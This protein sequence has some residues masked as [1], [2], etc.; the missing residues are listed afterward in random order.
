MK[1]ALLALLAAAVFAL[2]GGL[3]SAQAPG[4]SATTNVSELLIGQRAT[5]EV[6]VRVPSGAT[7]E[8]DTGADSWNGVAVVA[9]NRGEVVREG[10]E[11]V[12]R[13]ALIVAPF[14]PGPGS[15]EPSI[16]VI[17]ADGA[18]LRTLPAI[19]W[20]V[21]PSLSPGAPL[22]ISPLAEPTGIAGAESPLLRPAIGL[23]VVVTLGI[24]AAAVFFAAR[25]IARSARNRPSPEVVVEAP[26]AGFEDVE[27]LL[28][29][30]PVGA[31]RALS[32]IVRGV[33]GTRYG[34]PANALTTGELRTRM[35]SSGAD[36]FQARLVGGFLENCDSVI[37]AGYRPAAE[38]RHA[39]LN[40]AR[41]I[42]EAAG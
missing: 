1:R 34:L 28:D 41:E 37:Y 11:D 40:M 15:F 36:R 19:S 25:A 16:A 4:D 42:V 35:E 20:N 21:V 39:D 12:H 31:Y 9:V 32:T 2:P 5:V 3:S 18:T 14:V 6:E 10:S 7:V 33:I 22:E 38:R 30:D 8:V 27:P 29:R 26:P 23:G 17:T 24:V 13:L